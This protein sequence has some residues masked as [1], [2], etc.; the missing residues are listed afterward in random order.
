ML[1]RGGRVTYRAPASGLDLTLGIA[2]IEGSTDREDGPVRLKGEGQ[3]GNQP[4]RL[5]LRA[6]ALANL[7]T[8]AG[9]YPVDLALELGETRARLEGTLTNPWQLR[10]VDA[11]LSLEGPDL[12]A[13]APV[14]ADPPPELPPYAIDGRL[15]R[16]GD[17]WRLSDLQAAVGESRLE[18]E[19]RIETG[20]ERPVVNAELISQQ[21]NYA[22]FDGFQQPDE[23]PP[24]PLDLRFLK[25]FD[26][27]FSVRGEEVKTPA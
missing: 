3:L 23:Q 26:A 12:T 11:R 19:I 15:R 7:N 21:Q 9:P 16:T 18:G 24:E 27:A 2:R 6:G 17:T 4:W 22:D 8:A 25:V 14:L 20:V 5:A 1:I 13:L 10:G